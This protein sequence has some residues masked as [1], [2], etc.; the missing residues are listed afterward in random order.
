[1]AKYDLGIC[2]GD[3][4]ENY[5]GNSRMNRYGVF[6]GVERPRRIDELHTLDDKGNLL[7][8]GYDP[9]SSCPQVSDIVDLGQMA[10]GAWYSYKY[11]G[12]SSFYQRPV[13]VS[14]DTKAMT[15]SNPSPVSSAIYLDMHPPDR[16]TSVQMDYIPRKDITHLGLYRTTAK[17]SS[18]AALAGTWQLVMVTSNASRAQPITV[19][20]MLPDALLGMEIETD[21]FPPPAYRNATEAEG[22]IWAGGGRA[23]GS[24]LTCTVTK[25]SWGVTLD[26]AGKKF[27]DGIR[28]WTFSVLG[29][30]SDGLDGLG[31]YYAWYIS[32]TILQL[33]DADN[34]PYPY[35][36]ESGSG[37]QFVCFLDGRVLRWSKY[38][39]PEAWP[40]TNASLM[41]TEVTG[42]KQ[43]P[44]QPMLAVVTDM[45]EI[46]I[47]DLTSVGTPQFYTSMQISDEFTAYQFT[48][49]PV[50]GRLR[51]LDTWR[52]CIWECDGT[53]VRDITR[54]ILNDVWKYLSLDTEKQENWHGVYDAHQKIFAEFVTLS[55]SQRTVDFSIL[56][57]VRTGNW[58]FNWEKD[59]LCSCPVFD[60]KTGRWMAFGGT[61][62]LGS[63]GGTWGRIW[64]PDHYNDWVYPN[65]LI[66][67]DITAATPTVVTVDN[68]GGTDLQT[69]GDGLKGR[70]VLVTDANGENEQL[71]LI[72][73]NTVDT[74][75]VDTVYGGND[76]NQF[77]PLP[78]STWKFYLGLI[79]CKWGPKRFVMEDPSEMK[80]L[81]EFYARIKSA[82]PNNPPF[83]RTF[84][85][86]ETT[87]RRQVSLSRSAYVGQ[88][89]TEQ[90]RN[91]PSKG[92]LEGCLQFGLTFFDR[93]YEPIE[94]E[95]ITLV[96][97]PARR[98]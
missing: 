80:Q 73:N 65:S 75:T 12:L 30:T 38:Q 95:D 71:G 97:N 14:D 55:T 22:R 8:L 11:I 49:T 7:L 18:N 82:D 34:N 87:H 50:E 74:I 24:G 31:H 9:P 20:D 86:I 81:V 57:N 15:R 33:R 52:G 23:I 76:D 88:T 5:A 13:P 60:P 21:N 98:K 44:N 59:L 35:E 10:S 63:S 39:E 42:I 70:W 92:M 3:Y 90:W 83:I 66:S 19:I 47:F 91:D 2:Q 40:L 29:D 51:G 89:K 36:G 84:R 72:T 62:G 79:E 17:D 77:N 58:W 25:G 69:A 26:T 16:A 45:P 85:G 68:S 56:Q 32:D 96:F 48:L 93:S 1:M 53:S 46:R 27:Y 78:D 61:E 67:G 6:N 43:I 37:K 41:R 28:G 4:K 94:V 54:G 64:T